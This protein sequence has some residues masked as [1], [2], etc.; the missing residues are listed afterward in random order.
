MFYLM[1]EGRTV[2]GLLNIREAVKQSY[3]LFNTTCKIG[4]KNDDLY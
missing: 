1:N 4:E 3:V 2:Y